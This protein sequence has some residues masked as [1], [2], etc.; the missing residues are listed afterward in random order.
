VIELIDAQERYVPVIQ[1]PAKFAT[2]IDELE[3]GN[4]NDES[5][6]PPAGWIDEAFNAEHA[7]ILDNGVRVIVFDD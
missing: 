1:H 2:G 5:N 7:W 4:G 3:S 6:E